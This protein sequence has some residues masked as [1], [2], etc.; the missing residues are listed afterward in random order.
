MTSLA[1]ELWR[2]HKLVISCYMLVS[3][4]QCINAEI[5]E[6]FFATTYNVCHPA[7]EDVQC[8]SFLFYTTIFILNTRALF[9]TTCIYVQYVTI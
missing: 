8:F 9:K 1:I 7:K 2:K 5:H 4:S 3:R 6:T